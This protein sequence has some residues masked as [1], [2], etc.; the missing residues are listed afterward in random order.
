LR[1]I[2][3]V[4][5]ATAVPSDKAAMQASKNDPHT[6]GDGVLE[7]AIRRRQALTGVK[8]RYVEIGRHV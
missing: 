5:E 2:V 7:C 4:S 6:S 3:A 8:A 1:F